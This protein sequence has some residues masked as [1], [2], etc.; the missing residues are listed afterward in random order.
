MDTNKK[1]AVCE[2]VDVS[3]KNFVAGLESRYEAEAIDPNGV[4]NSKKNNCHVLS[5]S[6]L[7]CLSYQSI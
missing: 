1:K 5:F 4:I 6:I 2:I 7:V 3:I